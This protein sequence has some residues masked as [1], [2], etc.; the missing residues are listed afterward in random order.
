MERPEADETMTVDYTVGDNHPKSND[1]ND[2]C[3]RDCGNPIDVDTVHEADEQLV[4]EPLKVLLLCLEALPREINIQCSIIIMSCDISQ[5]FTSIVSSIQPT[6]KLSNSEKRKSDEQTKSS[7]LC[8]DEFSF[9]TRA[10]SLHSSLQVLSSYLKRIHQLTSGTLGNPIK[11]RLHAELTEN[12]NVLIEQCTL[13]LGQLKDLI[14]TDGSSSSSGSK[15][16]KP[17]KSNEERSNRNQLISHRS[18]IHKLLT[19]E[20][21]NLRKLRAIEMNRQQRLVELSGNLATGIRSVT[22]S[23]TNISAYFKSSI[24]K[25]SIIDTELRKRGYPHIESINYRKSQH[26]LPT[27]EVENLNENELRTL[28]VENRM[29]YEQFTQEK[30]ELHLVAKNISEIGR[31]NQTLS[32]HLAEQL[33]TTEKISD[34]SVTATEYIRQGNELLREAINS[35][36]NIQ[37]WILFIL[38][39][40][41]LSLHFLDWFYP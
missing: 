19:E 5:L 32:E 28:E 13:L 2:N 39:I 24:K 8:N 11:Q 16:D 9:Q 29:L 38:I 18:A 3:D 33:E 30:D 21:D 12:V 35:K 17:M 7:G 1:P 20:L 26:K 27:E 23:G 40:L 15:L 4:Y 34:S 14:S 22:A 31:L 36:A 41:T 25:D 10:K 6:C 37:F